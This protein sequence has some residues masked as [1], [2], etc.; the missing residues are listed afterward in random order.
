MFRCVIKALATLGKAIATAV[1]A[2]VDC[3]ESAARW[4]WRAHSHRMKSDASYAA[5]AAIVLG[6]V[7]GGVPIKD[8]VAAVLAVVF[9]IA[10]SGRGSYARPAYEQG[11]SR[12][13]TNP[14]WDTD[15]DT[16]FA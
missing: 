12:W 7:F 3:A 8:A 4:L 5:A 10:L 1:K 13:N 16:D 15:P 9:G 14:D 6:T 11:R 2:V